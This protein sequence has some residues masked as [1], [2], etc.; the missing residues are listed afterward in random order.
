MPRPKKAN[1]GD[2]RYELKRV[3]G[4]DGDGNTLRKSFYGKN[5]AEAL[6]AYQKFLEDRE[7]EQQERRFTPFEKWVDTWLYT[8]KEP[9]VKPTTFLTTYE[10]PCERYIKPYFSGKFLQDISQ[11]DI[12]AFLNSLATEYS[13]SFLDKIVICL[14]GIFDQLP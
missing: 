9:D 2:G 5:E 4:R 6:R 11:A 1:R 7:K 14:R 12:K 8:Y 13:Q 3:I 10:R